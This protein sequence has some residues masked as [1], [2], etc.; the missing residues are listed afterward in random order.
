MECTV[1]GQPMHYE[2]Y[3]EGIPLIMLHGRP[4]AGTVMAAFM[5]PVFAKRHGW[6]R[7]YLDMPGMGQTPAH[8]N[9]QNVDGLLE[10]VLEF[11]RQVIPG[12]HFVLAGWSFGGYIARGVLRQ[13][14]EMVDGLLLIV[15]VIFRDERRTSPPPH[16]TLV[17]DPALASQLE[18][19]E[20]L[21]FD[22]VVVVQNRD[23]WELLRQVR[24]DALRAD[25]T[26]LSRLSGGFSSDPDVLSERFN[27]PSLF[28]M[29]RQD[30]IAGYSDIW[31]IYDIYPR[32]TLAVLDRAGHGLT[33]EQVHLFE[34]LVYE[35][36]DRV[37]ESRR[38][39]PL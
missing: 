29:G 35:W 24:V 28:I 39:R 19:E 10:T 5:E 25:Q 3:G 36:L 27:R 6:Q 11:I 14:A 17:P 15:P 33:A 9:I 30:A 38:A 22:S 21:D 12:R 37:E 7:L 13:K 8:Q 32:G 2:T 18:E 31:K 34:A 23:T 16:V 1:F 26:F 20:R 4:A